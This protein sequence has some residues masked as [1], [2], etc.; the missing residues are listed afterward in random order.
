MTPHLSK[1]G[2]QRQGS[3]HL[4]LLDTHL[5]RPEPTCKKPE[6]A[7]LWESP[8]HEEKPH[9]VV[10]ANIST[11]S[12]VD[13]QICEW[14]CLQKNPVTRCWLT[15]DLS[16]PH[17][18]TFIQHQHP[19][20]VACLLLSWPNN[21]QSLGIIC[22]TAVGNQRACFLIWRKEACL[23]YCFMLNKK[24]ENG[25]ESIH[26]NPDIERWLVLSWFSFPWHQRSYS[27][28]NEIGMCTNSSPTWE[29]GLGNGKAE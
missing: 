22:Y 21:L 8:S 6:A 20:D 1:L 5:W 16:V 26:M 28:R 17:L 23:P 25:N 11:W 9:V 10:L 12:P 7:V 2:Q 14:S 13:S 24:G 27:V 19:T 15:R 4:V 3:W 29:A 18:Q